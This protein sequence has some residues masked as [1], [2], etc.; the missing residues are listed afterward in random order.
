MGEKGRKLGFWY[1]KT[2]SEKNEKK[3]FFS[4]FYFSL[5]LTRGCFAAS[6]IKFAYKKITPGFLGLDFGKSGFP[7]VLRFEMIEIL[8][9]RIEHIQIHL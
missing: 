7:E 4:D 3:N 8:M 6:Y 1:P 2:G 5:L 9:I